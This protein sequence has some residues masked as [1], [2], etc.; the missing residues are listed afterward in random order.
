MCSTFGK[1]YIESISEG[2]RRFQLHKYIDNIENQFS[3]RRNAIV[4]GA[5]PLT[6]YDLF[7]FSRHIK[8]CKIKI[9]V[10]VFI[11]EMRDHTSGARSW[12]SWK[13]IIGQKTYR[14]IIFLHFYL[15]VSSG[16][17]QQWFSNYCCMGARHSTHL[18]STWIPTLFFVKRKVTAWAAPWRSTVCQIV[19]ERWISCGKPILVRVSYDKLRLLAPVYWNRKHLSSV[20]LCRPL[21]VW[22]ATVSWCIRG[23]EE[24]EK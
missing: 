11:S 19:V 8:K 7:S 6:S 14:D 13:S 23:S 5:L 16:D 18:Q 10:C 21:D 17:L 1:G 3:W 9:N 22:Y 4:A 15:I 2:Q 20:F 12:V 24:M